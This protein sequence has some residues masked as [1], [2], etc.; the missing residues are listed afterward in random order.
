MTIDGSLCR[1]SLASVHEHYHNEI[2]FK[3]L[4]AGFKREWASMEELYTT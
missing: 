3:D 2:T 4:R 1:K